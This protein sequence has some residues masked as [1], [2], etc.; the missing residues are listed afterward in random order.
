MFI[1]SGK[2][3]ELVRLKPHLLFAYILSSQILNP[4]IIENIS[5]MMIV[6]RPHPLIVPGN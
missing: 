4:G 3:S 6:S 2:L 5:A 1:F